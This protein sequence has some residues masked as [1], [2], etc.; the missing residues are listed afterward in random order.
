MFKVCGA[1]N[2]IFP[3]SKKNKILDMSSMFEMTSNLKYL[4]LSGLDTSSVVK[5]NDMFYFSGVN[6]LD[7]SSFNT[8]LIEDMSLMFNGCTNLTS[9]NL[10]SFNTSLVKEMSYMFYYCPSLTSLDLSNFD[11]SNVEN[12]EGMFTYCSSLT[13]LDLS[14]FDTSNVYKLDEMFS[15]CINLISLNLSSFNTSK[16][17]DIDEM[18]FDCNSLILLDISNFDLNEKYSDVFTGCSSLSYIK[19]YSYKGPD[20]FDSIQNNNLIY[21]ANDKT[22]NKESI[23][24]LIEKNY[25][26]NCSNT[27][28]LNAFCPILNTSIPETDSTKDSS[29]NELLKNI[30]ISALFI[31]TILILLILYFI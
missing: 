12:M 31:M 15:G 1:K 26:N 21:C 10:S 27:C 17:S 13:S 30:I 9:L 29:F 28:F 16:V 22:V 7:L 14:N 25:T 4:D 24:S 6:T 2:I 20:N 3:K 18:F 8:S 5:M 11:T 23:T 19:I